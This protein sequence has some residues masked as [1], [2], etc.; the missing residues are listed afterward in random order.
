MKQGYM[1]LLLLVCL[2]GILAY[3]YMKPKRMHERFE[4]SPK[5]APLAECPTKAQRTPDGHIQVQ[6]GN[7]VFATMKEYLDYLNGLYASGSKCIPPKVENNTQ[8]IPGIMGGLGTGKEGS[9]SVK[10]QGASREVLDYNGKELAYA[11]TPINNLDDYEYSRVFE[12]ENTSRNGLSNKS[13]SELMNNHKT[14]W[15][16]LPFN[17]EK[18]S[19]KEDEFVAGRLEDVYREPV[20]GVFFK[21]IDGNNVIPPNS[22]ALHQREQQLLA[23]Y[24]PSEISKHKVS[25]EMETVGQ[26]VNK[27]YKE[28]PNWEP[29]V[30]KVSDHQWEIS[31]LIP[32]R[33]K[34]KY[35]D[36]TTV[37]L[38]LAE[39]TGMA[40]PLPNITIDDHNR[41][42]P[43]F[44][45]SGVGDKDNNKFWRY[46]DFTKWTPGL[47]RMF[48]P[49]LA[50][51]E[52]S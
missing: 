38:S 8:P 39:Q 22:E 27:L 20:T 37:S 5:K 50:N 28:D 32:K 30:T 36:E 23:E 52:W 7:K 33:K 11:K 12:S 43:Y 24:K 44:D 15:A 41:A 2:F 16:N 31:E 19:A 14:D 6:P 48:A 10:M 35:E 1:I 51:K 25:S 46:E 17:S 9:E 42:D 13:K 34:E 3:I 45:K 21:N 26:L 4:D 18:R 47:E 29:V 49:T 40:N